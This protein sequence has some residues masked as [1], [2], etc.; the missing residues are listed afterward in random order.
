MTDNTETRQFKIS[1][2]MIF[3]TIESQAGSIE[4]AI[5]EC[6]M[7]AV[8]AGA[9]HVAVDITETGYV[10]S[11]N[12][13]GFRT[14]DEIL[15]CFEVFGFDHQTE[16]EI[17]KGRTFGTFGIGRAQLW[18][19][20]SNRWLTNKFSLDVDIKNKGL[21]YT[22]TDEASLFEGCKIIGEFYQPQSLSDLQDINRALVHLALYLPIH[23][24]LNDKVVS[25]K[26]EDQKWTHDTDQAF[27]K[28]NDNGMLEVYNLGVFVCS[29][30]NYI[31]GKGG[32]VV[33][34]VQLSLNTARNDILKSKCNVWKTVH[35]YLKKTATDDNL[36]SVALDDNS[37]KNLLRQWFDNDISYEQLKGKRLLPDITGRH[38]TLSALSKFN[39]KFSISPKKSSQVGETIHASQT[40]FVFPSNILDWFDVDDR[41]E[42][43]DKLT[44]LYISSNLMVRSKKIES[45]DFEKISD[46]Y[47]SS[48]AIIDNNKY[49]KKQEQYMSLAHTINKEIPYILNSY[50][51]NN[52]DQKVETRNLVLGKSKN[53]N[54]WTDSLS[55]IGL[56]DQFIKCIDDGQRGIQKVIY[57]LIHEYLHNESSLGDH[58]HSEEFYEN[59]H[60]IILNKYTEINTI[61]INAKPKY[62]KLLN[63]NNLAF[64]REYLR[65]SKREIEQAAITG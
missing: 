42:L 8:D 1:T 46:E 58:A 29:F 62:I 2:S 39:F 25:K 10:I 34:K 60:N 14:K 45:L 33:S 15:S 12:G 43:E 44:K 32:L 16:D 13:R 31:F 27:I 20:S 65:D 48:Y 55:Y 26:L 59:F 56:S 38:Q 21:D 23:F 11:D 64:P 41:F 24:T 63:K 61:L 5:L 35:K 49:T 51:L 9:T 47:K 36:K 37:R 6:L 40:C 18:A 57:I 53:A 7:N 28:L 3:H 30:P 4:K 19:F 54:A 52:L 17:S 22:L 50:F